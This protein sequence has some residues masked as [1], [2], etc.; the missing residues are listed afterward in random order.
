MLTDDLTWRL[1]EAASAQP[2]VPDIDKALARA[3]RVRHRHRVTAALGVGSV[4]AAA[5]VGVVAVPSRAHHE[6]PATVLGQ[7]TDA[8]SVALTMRLDRTTD[9]TCVTLTFTETGDGIDALCARQDRA[10]DSNK[11]GLVA[12]G[13]FAEL[14]T[15]TGGAR[16]V[17]AVGAVAGGGEVFVTDEIGQQVRATILA[18][19]TGMSAA[20]FFADLGQHRPVR[21]TYVAPNGGQQGVSLPTPAPHG[22]PSKS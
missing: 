21:E 1:E 9:V 5:A 13:N 3:R 19:P 16:H 20:P 11:S 22:A 10:K 14:R 15:R 6:V 12:S 8:P 4:V 7:A 18:P 17:V 2:F